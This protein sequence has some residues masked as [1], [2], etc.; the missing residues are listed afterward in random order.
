MQRYQPVVL[1]LNVPIT[2]PSGYHGKHERTREE[3]ALNEVRA[4]KQALVLPVNLWAQFAVL[5]LYKHTHNK[6][7]TVIIQFNFSSRPV[8]DL[9]W[10]VWMAMLCYHPKVLTLFS[11]VCRYVVTFAP[12]RSRLQSLGILTFCHSFQE[13]TARSLT[14]A[15]ANWNNIYLLRSS[16]F[17]HILS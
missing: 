12:L 4:I 15:I 8:S 3:K 16:L 14:Q 6:F 5:N 17:E 11:R 13:R 9:T 7:E 1:D 2:R 10:P